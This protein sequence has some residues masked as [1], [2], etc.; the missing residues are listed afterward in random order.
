MIPKP[1]NPLDKVPKELFKKLTDEDIRVIQAG[2][3]WHLAATELANLN[4]Q[5]HEDFKEIVRI[6]AQDNPKT[7]WWKR[8]AYRA[9]F[10]WIEGYD[11]GMKQ[12]ALRAYVAGAAVELSRSEIS[13]LYEET[14]NIDKGK[15][16]TKNV[17]IPLESNIRFT[18]SVFERIYNL[19][20]MIDAGSKDWQDFRSAIKVRNRLTHPKAAE[21]LIVTENEL[22]LLTAVLNWFSQLSTTAAKDATSYTQELRK[23]KMSEQEQKQSKYFASIRQKL[24]QLAIVENAQKLVDSI[25]RTEGELFLSKD[26]V[27]NL[28]QELSS[29]RQQLAEELQERS[30]RSK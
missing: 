21:D 15:T 2:H 20:P 4:I 23:I 11:Y 6:G 3:D 30:K 14:Y 22:M 16:R 7:D 5:L 18:F 17:F 8:S 9:M 1:E 10:A 12:V 29:L 24:G 28:D 27:N 25:T 19:K 26:T 13:F